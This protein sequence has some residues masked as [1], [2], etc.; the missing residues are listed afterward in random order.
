MKQF[1]L[2]TAGGQPLPAFSFEAIVALMLAI[3]LLACS[4]ARAATA[5]P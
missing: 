2:Y 4:T 3:V 1:R 5:A